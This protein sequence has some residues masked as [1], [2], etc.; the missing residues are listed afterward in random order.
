M[1]KLATDYLDK[2]DIEQKIIKMSIDSKSRNIVFNKTKVRFVED[3]Y[4]K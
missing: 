3:V 2:Y 1:K 4:K